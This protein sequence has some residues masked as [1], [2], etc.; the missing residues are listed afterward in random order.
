MRR[1]RR[2]RRLQASAAW[3]ARAWLLPP[4]GLVLLTA[5][6]VVA[7]GPSHRGM[8]LA[9]TPLV[10]VFTAAFGPLVLLS[11]LSAVLRGVAAARI[12][13]LAA[14][15]GVAAALASEAGRPLAV[16]ERLGGW[17]ITATSPPAAE[18]L[19][20]SAALWCRRGIPA[21][22]ALLVLGSVVAALPAVLA[23][24]GGGLDLAVATALGGGLL[25]AASRPGRRAWVW[26][27][28]RQPDGP[29]RVRP[30]RLPRPHRRRLQ[31]HGGSEPPLEIDLPAWPGS[32]VL[33]HRL[34]AT[35]P[36]AAAAAMLGPAGGLRGDPPLPSSP[37]PSPP[38][39]PASPVQPAAAADSASTAAITAAGS[40]CGS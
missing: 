4:A 23:S 19:G 37:P 34:A 31:L 28:T 22:A 6:G 25:I 33:R 18:P 13:R 2:W 29:A 36:P 30:A 24:R 11:L 14:E 10:S 15:P 35:L 5:A 7:G 1:L 40:D 3:S 27:S 26:S 17:R 32:A 20:G 9:W 38:A 16:G 39:A 21:A 12:R 8:P